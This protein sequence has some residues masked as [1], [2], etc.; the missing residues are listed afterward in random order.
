MGQKAN[1]AHEHPL[2]RAIR[3]NG[4]TWELKLSRYLRLNVNNSYMKMNESGENMA[5]CAGL[6][7]WETWHIFRLFGG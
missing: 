6:G 1:H 5:L 7:T 3:E 2:L 4:R